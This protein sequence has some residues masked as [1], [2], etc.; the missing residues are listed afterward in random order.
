MGG[1][2]L[3]RMAR[4]SKNVVVEGLRGTLGNQI[5]FKRDKAGRTIVSKKPEFGPDRVFSEA[6]K[7]QQGRFREAM[8]CAKDAARREGIYVALA[9]GMPRTSYNVAVRDCFNPPVVE[10]GTSGYAGGAETAPLALV[11]EREKP[12]GLWVAVGL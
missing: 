3:C 7:A 8:A 11:F 9:E 4:A 12:R 2:P 6:Q 5:V 10:V 1:I